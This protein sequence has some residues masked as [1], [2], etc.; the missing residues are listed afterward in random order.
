MKYIV[1]IFALLLAGCA[2][3]PDRISR[4]DA[5]ELSL[6]WWAGGLPPVVVDQR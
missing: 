6:G 1:L 5:K 2:T 4:K 3:V